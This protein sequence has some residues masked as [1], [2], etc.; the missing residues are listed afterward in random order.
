MNMRLILGLML[1]LLV[2]YVA[3]TQWPVSSGGKTDVATTTDTVMPAETKTVTKAVSNTKTA[4]PVAASTNVQFCPLIT[5]GIELGSKDPLQSPAWAHGDVGKLQVFLSRKYGLDET[6]FVDGIFGEKT[7]TYLKRYQKEI[8]LPQSGVVDSRTKDALITPCISGLKANGVE[9]PIKNFTFAVE[10]VTMQVN[11]HETLQAVGTVLQGASRIELISSDG[12]ARI[13]V[14][15]RVIDG[16]LSETFTIGKGK[17]VITTNW[18]LALKIKVVN[19]AP[20]SA[21]LSISQ[22]PSD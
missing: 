18:P 4:A 13:R 2:G 8:G 22:V 20:N 14:T 7:E 15:G 1:A 5:T 6:T 9:Y 3:Y 19:L 12:A 21:T 10:G 17:E 11:V 16:I